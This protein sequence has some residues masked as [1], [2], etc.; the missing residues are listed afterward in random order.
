MHH[1][2][3]WELIRTAVAIWKRHTF[4]EIDPPPDVWVQAL[5]ESDLLH[6]VTLIDLP[7]SAY[8]PSDLVVGVALIALGP[9]HAGDPPDDQWETLRQIVQ[10]EIPH[11]EPTYWLEVVIA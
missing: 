9:R 11:A 3:L 10:R 8:T 7:E 6:I 1:Q 4:A 5:R 2:N